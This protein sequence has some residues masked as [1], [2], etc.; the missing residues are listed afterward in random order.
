MERIDFDKWRAYIKAVEAQPG[1]YTAQDRHLAELLTAWL[2][3]RNRLLAQYLDE[4]AKVRQLEYA[5]SEAQAQIA[6]Y[7]GRP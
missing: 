1:D 3:D 5:L 7:R 6:Y 2:D 4:A